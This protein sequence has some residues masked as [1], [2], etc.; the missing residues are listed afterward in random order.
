M[1]KKTTVFKE[2]T[3]GAVLGAILVALLLLV[4][5]NGQEKGMKY[6]VAY[7]L[8]YIMKL[9][10]RYEIVA[11]RDSHVIVSLTE[12][13]RHEIVIL[14]D[15]GFTFPY[16]VVEFA[17]TQPTDRAYRVCLPTGYKIDGE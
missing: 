3:V 7:H 5:C 6:D 13:P 8:K 9:N 14:K 4:G 11:S 1:K 2:A 16:V 17:G 15:K 12:D 10:N